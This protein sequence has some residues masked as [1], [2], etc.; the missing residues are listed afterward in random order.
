MDYIF[1][2][3]E[4]HGRFVSIEL[5]VHGPFSAE[6]FDLQLPSWRPGR[7]ETGNFAKNIKGFSVTDQDGTSLPFKKVTKDCWRIS[8]K[9]HSATIRYQYF[10]A[11]PDAGACFLDHELL[12]INPVHCCFYIPGREM[13]PCKVTLKIPA[14]WKIATGM[15]ITDEHILHASDFHQLVDCPFM[16]SPSLSHAHYTLDN[17]QFNI[18]FQGEAQPEWPKILKDFKAFTEVQL[19]TMKEFP[20]SNYHFL[21]LLVPFP[22]YHG[23]EH[24]NST[25]LAL[26]PGYKLMQPDMYKEL[27]GVASHELFHSWNVKSIRPVEMLPYNYTTENYAETGYVYEGVTTYYGD[28]FLARSGYFSLSAL[29]HEYSVRLQ[30]HTDN[31]GIFNYSVAESSFDT[32]LDGYTPGVP[33][34]KTSI[35]DEGC[36]LAL[37]LD[38]MI[39]SATASKHSLDDV[40]RVLYFE[41][42]KKN[43]GYT[44]NDFREIAE[45]IAGRSFKD[46]FENYIY[47]ATSLVSLLGEI[48]SLAGLRLIET[49]SIHNQERRWGVKTEYRN[50]QLFVTSV[51]P[52]SPAAN[53][54]LFKEDELIFLNGIRIDNNISELIALNSENAQELILS[55]GKKI[56]KVTLA[57]SEKQYYN[58]YTIE[59]ED[60]ISAGQLNF[61]QHWLGTI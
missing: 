2:I 4:P 34:R 24:L 52:G 61:R 49:P 3:S 1:S 18:W 10:A 39:R 43:K 45:T 60:K 53:A 12:Y 25:V 33:G 19:K 47:K 40:M 48:V 37:S 30:K 14:G 36:L 58:R 27:L 44:G 5:L 54:N 9:M 32:W 15:N 22:F 6:G 57:V 35:Y 28:L 42:A 20:A 55:S 23:V 8:G 59:A 38:F 56:K 51:Y 31:P 16:A 41:Y 7:Y 26:G 46:F 13:D 21:V 17:I 50:G 29:L 11:Q